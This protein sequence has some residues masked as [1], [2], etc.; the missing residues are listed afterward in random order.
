V[1]DESVHDWVV[2]CIDTESGEI[3]WKQI[4]YTGVP[5]QKRHPMSSHASASMAANGDYAVAFFGSEGLYCYDMEGRLQ[6]KND[7]GMLRSVFFVAE[8]A[9]WEWASSPIIHE[10]VVLI[11]VDVMDQSFVAALDVKTGDELW[12]TNREE[13]PHEYRVRN[14]GHSWEYWRTALPDVLE[15]V[16]KGFHR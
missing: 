16:T 6:W 4:A 13:I 14:G 5:K 3:L 10:D 8:D 11:Q 1:A 12:R 15:F 9:E 2:Y 7:Y